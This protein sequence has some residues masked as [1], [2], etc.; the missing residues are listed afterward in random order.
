M[1]ITSQDRFDDCTITETIGIAT[2]NTVR[3][4]HVG[5]D[6]AAGLRNIVG[7]EAA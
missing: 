2:G 4:R 5:A 1:K 7:G 3:A 6:F